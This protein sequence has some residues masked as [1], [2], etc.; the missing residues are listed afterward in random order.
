MMDIVTMRAFR[1]ELEKIATMEEAKSPPGFLSAAKSPFTETAR[2]LRPSTAKDAWK[3]LWHGSRNDHPLNKQFLH[4]ELH[5][6]LDPKTGLRGT[7]NPKTGLREGGAIPNLKGVGTYVDD[8]SHGKG[9]RADLRRGGWLANMAKYEGPSMWRKG[10]NAVS[11][12]LPGQRTML[13]GGSALQAHSDLQKREAGTGRERGAGE[14]VL[15]TIGGQMGTLGASTPTAI[16]AM[17]RGGLPS[18][19]GGAL[20]ATALGIAG[21]AGGK[22]LGRKV[23][24]VRGFKPT[25]P[26]EQVPG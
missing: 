7:L 19:V 16:R 20:G 6:E 24:Q 26:P 1:S 9:V 25:P 17:T 21:S 8:I 2:L 10:V 13:L 18:M 11:R 12:H 5:G 14:R 15:G 23:D 22:F 4:D 3:D